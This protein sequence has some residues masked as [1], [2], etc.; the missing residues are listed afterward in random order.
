M[1]LTVLCPNGHRQKVSTT[2]NMSLQQVL[3]TVCTKKK[4]DS[5]K[6]KLIHHRNKLDLSSSIRFSGLPNNCLIEMEELTE[7]E[8]KNVKDSLVSVCL[9]VASGERLIKEFSCGSTLSDVLNNFDQEKM[10]LPEEGE[11][12]VIVYLRNEI[13]GSELLTKTTLRSLGLTTGKGL[14]RF[15]FKKP[16]ALKEQ[17][18]VYA[19]KDKAPEFKKDKSEERRH[20]PMR[21]E[22]ATLADIQPEKSKAELHTDVNKVVT[23]ENKSTNSERIEGNM[24]SSEDKGAV[25]VTTMKDDASLPVP[26]QR[27]DSTTL[28]ED[29]V[30]AI[31]NPVGPNE[32]IIFQSEGSIRFTLPD[33]GDEDFFQHTLEDVK[34]RYKALRLEMKEVDEGEDM[35]TQDMKAS[36]KEGEKLS[37]L[38]RY[39][40]SLVR[41]QFPS[42]H[43]VQGVFKPHHTIGEIK[44]W[45]RPLLVTPDLSFQLYIVPPRTVLQDKESLLDL[46]LV[47]ASLIH[48][49][50]PEQ[51]DTQ[52]WI[53]Q[54][55]L[56][57][58]SNVEGA[59]KAASQ[60]RKGGKKPETGISGEY[61][62]KQALASIPEN[63]RSSDAGIPNNNS[64]PVIQPSKMPKWFKPGK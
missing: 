6:H 64:N 56:Q 53:H 28:E 3:E 34:G 2:P 42:R 15:S 10:G 9:Q 61:K 48:F 55:H 27:P 36:R 24:T 49:S 19:I 35:L 38:G 54:D 46:N 5:S 32:A 1:S 31:L 30:E 18:N 59:N 26:S 58:L 25:N 33:D 8:L 60:F 45:L 17:A 21:M 40:S 39:K 22:P 41:I 14:F 23:E 20:L 50:V 4:F 62:G 52:H 29:K 43:T 12:P 57:N 13:I 47:P 51:A 7:D 16:E 11:E 63:S 44:D 37:M